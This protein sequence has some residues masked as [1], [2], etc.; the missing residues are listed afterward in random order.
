M[1]PY[2]AISGSIN[3]LAYMTILRIDSSKHLL[4]E[5]IK[6]YAEKNPGAEVNIFRW[7]VGYASKPTVE[8]ERLWSANYTE[9]VDA[10]L[11][12][13]ISPEPE[14]DIPKLVIPSTE[15]EEGN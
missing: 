5:Y 3:N 14:P 12:P 4:D 1:Y 9:P 8:V 11:E 15:Y 6:N 2:V 7:E 13:V 10:S